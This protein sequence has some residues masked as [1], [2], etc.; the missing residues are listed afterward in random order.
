ML[1][2]G[3]SWAP[4]SPGGFA[5]AATKLVG[6]CL[7]SSRDTG[8]LRPL[9]LEGLQVHRRIG[10]KAPV[11]KAEGLGFA[12]CYSDLMCEVDW[13][14]QRGWSSPRIRPLS[15]VPVH[16]GITGLHYSISCLEGMKAC[17]AQD[18]RLLLFRPMDHLVRFQ[19]SAERLAL[20]GPDPSALLDLI[21]QFVRLEKD[22]VLGDRGC[23]LYLRPLLFSTYATLGVYPSRAAKLLVLGC[24]SGAYFREAA[25]VAAAA[26]AL[27]AI[28]NLLR[29]VAAFAAAAAAVL[30]DQQQQHQVQQQ[31]GCAAPQVP[32]QSVNKEC[33]LWTL[34]EN[35]DFLLT[36]AGAMSVFVLCVRGLLLAVSE[37]QIWMQKDLLPAL[38]GGKVME[39]FC[40]GTG[41]LTVSVGQL[42]FQGEVF[43][44]NPQKNEGGNKEGNFAQKLKE[45]ILDIQMGLVPGHPF[46]VEC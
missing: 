30:E 15:E 17:K 41:A 12:S 13:D 35:G 2:T 10:A 18:G 23:S 11:P 16:P 7:S 26:A 31:K 14:D 28:A 34:P 25:A 39:I 27:V 3:G 21:K 43:D 4:R 19:R 20:P 5:A 6:R 32:Q 38:R 42:H 33:L 40:S 37:R 9:S 36:E 24:P 46:V 29:A 22:Y 45:H 1:V 8:A 44:I